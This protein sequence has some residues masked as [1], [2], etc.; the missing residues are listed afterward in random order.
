MAV[1]DLQQHR[2]EAS[3]ASGGFSNNFIYEM[4]LRYLQR[5]G[6]SGKVLDFGAGQGGFI[7]H[8]LASGHFDDIAGADLMKRPDD[9]PDRVEWVQADLNAPLPISGAAFDAIAAIEVIEHLENPRGFFRECARLLKPGGVLVLTTP[10]CES[11]RSLI[12]L[13]VRG[14]FAAFGDNSYP[15]HITPVLPIDLRRA[16][17]EAGLAMRDIGFSNSGSLP[18]FPRIAWQALSFNLARG[19]RFSDNLAFVCRRE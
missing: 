9:L 4:A 14:H 2:I 3:I 7:S 1:Q 16:A 11:W 15:A 18:G 19:R 5:N 13:L 12:S 8:L 6:A 10:N 17:Q